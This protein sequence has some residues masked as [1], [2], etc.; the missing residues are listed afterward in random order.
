MIARARTGFGEPPGL[1]WVV[2]SF[3]EPIAADEPFD[4]AVCVGNSLALAPDRDAVRSAVLRMLA[5]VRPGGAIVVQVLN[6]WKLPDG[7]CVWQKC[8]RTSSSGVALRVVKGVHRCGGQGFVDLVVTRLA[9]SD[10][11]HAESVPLLGLEQAELQELARGGG[12]GEIHF[13]GG[14][15]EQPYDRQHSTDLIMLAVQEFPRAG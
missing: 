8:R 1:S 10:E 7:P 6:L 4:M 13:Y 15:D 12:A 2:R 14:Y 3:T 5:A 9:D 11:F